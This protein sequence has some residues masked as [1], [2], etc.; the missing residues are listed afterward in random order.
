MVQLSNKGAADEEQIWAA[1]KSGRTLEAAVARLE[2][3]LDE[4]QAAGEWDREKAER[5]V[6]KN[7]QDVQKHDGGHAEV[8][9][10][11]YH[12]HLGDSQRAGGQT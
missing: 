8:A 11:V 10:G 1:E 9:A 12:G 6:D 3:L 7:R 4:R 2:T 5:L